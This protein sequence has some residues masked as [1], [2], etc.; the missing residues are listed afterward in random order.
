SFAK[1]LEI[2]PGSAD[3]KHNAALSR[4]TLGDYRVGFAQYETR[5]ARSGMP[6]RRRGFGKPLWLGEYPPHRKT[7]LLHAEQGLGDTI[8]FARYAPLLA[9]MGAK[10]VLEGQA[11]VA[12]LLGR[13]DGVEAVVERGAPLPGFD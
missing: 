11:E 7:I 6:A 2:D 3:A 1:V 9:R 4:L 13:L 5:F 10:V 12:G 8:Q